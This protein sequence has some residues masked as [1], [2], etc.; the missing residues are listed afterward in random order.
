MHRNAQMG[1]RI[2]I[3]MVYV[4]MYLNVLQIIRFLIQMVHVGT[5]RNVLQIIRIFGQTA[6]A[7]TNLKGIQAHVQMIIRTDGLM[8][9]AMTYL[10]VAD[11][12]RTDG[13]MVNVMTNLNRIRS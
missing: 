13:Q 3:Q 8:V 1:I 11:T 9:N 2:Y 6:I 12:I 10:N 7:I 4:G 5:I